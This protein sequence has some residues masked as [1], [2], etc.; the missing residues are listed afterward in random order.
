MELLI[1]SLIIISI[2]FILA[3][4]SMKDFQDEPVAQ[5]DYRLFLIRN[6]AAINLDFLKKMSAFA[7]KNKAIFALERLF[8]GS[9]NVLVVFAPANF[10]EEFSSLEPLE[11]EDYL[12]SPRLLTVDQALTFEMEPNH[13]LDLNFMKNLKLESHQQFFWQMVCSPDKSSQGKF[14]LTIRAVV[15]DQTS[16]KRVELAK[17]LGLGKKSRKKSNK[18]IFE[19]FNKRALVPKEVTNFMVN[20]TQLLTFLGL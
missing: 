17:K 4:R 3:L 2:S 18:A 5:L 20:D 6:L 15:I 10:A 1:I 9:E 8:K 19:Q 11:L 16:Q 12:K 14:Q 7:L 13:K